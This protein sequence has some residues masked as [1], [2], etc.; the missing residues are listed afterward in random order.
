MP[1]FEYR[2]RQC[3]AEFEAL[4]KRQGD[5][6]TC[7]DCDSEELEQKFSTF[8]ATVKNSGPKCSVKESCPAAGSHQCGGCCA[9]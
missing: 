4:V 9:H 6:V 3:G 1:I 2:C 7:R 8:A 5:Q